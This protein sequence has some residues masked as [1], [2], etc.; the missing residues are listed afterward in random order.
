MERDDWQEVLRIR[1]LSD[2]PKKALGYEV[3]FLEKWFQPR[4]MTSFGA[5]PTG[6]PAGRGHR[7]Q[8]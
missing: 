8:R 5:A 7:S 6:R 3:P 4:P 2:I 1:P